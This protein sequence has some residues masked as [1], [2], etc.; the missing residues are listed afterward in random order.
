MKR[1]DVEVVRQ[2]IIGELEEAGKGGLNFRKIMAAVKTRYPR[3]AGR[4]VQDVLHKLEQA[5][6]IRGGG[7]RDTV[8]VYVSS[9]FVEDEPRPMTDREAIYAFRELTTLFR[10]PKPGRFDVR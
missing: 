10:G 6:E 8:R 9:K 7:V 4:F 1:S 5:A 3:V 2:M